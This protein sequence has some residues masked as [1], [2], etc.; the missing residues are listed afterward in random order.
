MTAANNAELRVR[1]RALASKMPA[2]AAQWP[3]HRA[4]QFKLD[5]RAAHRAADHPMASAWV[6]RQA[7]QTLQA[8]HRTSETA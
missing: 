5:L 7:L 8:Y 2:G 1:L 4:A 6:L 3:Q